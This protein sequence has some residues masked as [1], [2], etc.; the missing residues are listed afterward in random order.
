MCC[1]GKNKCCCIFSLSWGVLFFGICEFLCLIGISIAFYFKGNYAYLIYQIL[2]CLTFIVALVMRRALTARII[3][4]WVYFATLLV[5]LFSAFWSAITGGGIFGFFCTIA[6][7]AQ[8]ETDTKYDEFNCDAFMGPI[9]WLWTGIILAIGLPVKICGTQIMYGYKNQ[10]EDEINAEMNGNK[11][12]LI[13]DDTDDEDDK[14]SSNSSK[15]SHQ[16]P[17][18]L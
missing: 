4:F 3:L 2:V 15:S 17:K 6:E 18:S 7:K 11:E 1:V 5:F 9:I 8:E 12:R 14:K 16:A 10:L 13:N